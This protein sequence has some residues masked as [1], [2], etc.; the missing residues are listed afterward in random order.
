MKLANRW[1]WHRETVAKFLGMLKADRM[2]DTE[3]SNGFTLITILNYAK[4]QDKPETEPAA[5]P[6]AD[7]Q[8]DRQQAGSDTGINKKGKN[9][10][11]DE[12]RERRTPFPADFSITEEITDWAKSNDLPSLDLE[13]ELEKFRLHCL[14]KGIVFT[15]WTA[16][17]QSWL[18]KAPK[19]TRENGSA[20]PEE[21]RR[22]SFWD[23]KL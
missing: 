23:K 1:R 17:F 11:N 12:R 21:P 5:G 13:S 15:D 18:L 9:Y 6:T 19:F 2:I 4:Y 10:K 8:R 22:A 14:K 3:T 7:R 16:A 20:E